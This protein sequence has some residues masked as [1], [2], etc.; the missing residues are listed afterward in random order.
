M[1]NILDF[2]LICCTC[3]NVTHSTISVY[4]KDLKYSVSLA[5]MINKTSSIELKPTDDYPDK[6]CYTCADKLRI[7]YEFRLMCDDSNSILLSH[8]NQSKDTPAP[9]TLAEPEYE[10]LISEESV[11]LPDTSNDL[12]D[13]VFVEEYLEEYLLDSEDTA[14]SNDGQITEQQHSDISTSEDVIV[15]EHLDAVEEY[16]DC[17]TSDTKPAIATADE[18]AE[19][20]N[21]NQCPICGQILSKLAHLRRHLKIH[22]RT[23]T[24]SCT[25]C[26]KSFARSDNLRAHEKNHSLERRYKCPQ[27]SQRF[28]R[29]DA[30]KVH[31]YV[32]HKLYV[33]T[34]F[35]V[36][37]YC[38]TFFETKEQ[39]DTHIGK[40]R[41]EKQF[42]CHSCGK[43]FAELLRYEL[44]MEKH[45]TPTSD[46][47]TF[48]CFHCS[49]LFDSKKQ[50]AVHIRY[51]TAEKLYKCKYCD[52]A[53]ARKPDLKI[54]ED[55]HTGTKNHTC[56]T[57]GKS[58]Y[59]KS[60]LKT[61]MLTHTD[62]KPFLC[63]H[64][65]KRFSQKYDMIAHERRHTGERFQ[66]FMCTEQF[67]HA[68]QY[69][70]HLKIVHDCD[71][72]CRRR[73][74]KKFFHASTK[75]TE[76]ER[77]PPESTDK[78]N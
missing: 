70:S 46:T 34:H 22:T 20:V 39:L 19:Q 25:Q 17:D 33:E 61:H 74:V 56:R 76:T 66:C 69:N 3:L 40:H 62:E 64:C 59:Q 32:R 21:E 75:R 23:K 4:H 52:K 35:H 1:E 43:T 45:T 49:K 27:C 26:P 2:R 15:E 67:I 68:H 58:F 77:M 78:C 53:F 72:E 12:T 42:V 8:R 16:L 44:H 6:L 55:Y 60:T 28:K 57:C 9:L 10:D 13:V 36:C 31:M 50:L 47:E 14:P 5:E 11:P 29:M 18:D 7:A 71:V 38:N 37:S 48:E 63:S 65:P 54:H 24:F 51:H 73:S 41:R 30:V